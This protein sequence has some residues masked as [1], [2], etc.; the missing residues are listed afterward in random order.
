MATEEEIKGL[1]DSFAKD[2]EEAWK[3]VEHPADAWPLRDALPESDP[4]GDVDPM[5]Q[6][7]KD[8]EAYMAYIGNKTRYTGVDRNVAIKLPPGYK[9]AGFLGNV[10]PD[11]C[12]PNPHKYKNIITNSLKFWVCANCGADLGN[13]D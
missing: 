8:D 13:I 5:E 3:A 4:I 6:F 12:C 2:L 7:E 9:V 1:K 11:Q 10:K